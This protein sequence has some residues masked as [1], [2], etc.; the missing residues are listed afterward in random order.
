MRLPSL[1]LFWGV[2]TNKH[3]SPATFVNFSLK[4]VKSQAK[5]KRSDLVSIFYRINSWL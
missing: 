1:K 4:K 3:T 5:Y 2:I